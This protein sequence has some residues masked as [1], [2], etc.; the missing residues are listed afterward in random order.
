MIRKITNSSITILF[1]FLSS[2][3]FL[4]PNHHRMSFNSMDNHLK[5]WLSFDQWTPN[6]SVVLD[7]LVKL[8]VQF[9]LFFEV[10]IG[11]LEL[12][13]EYLEIFDY[14]E[15]VVHLFFFHLFLLFEGFFLVC[16]HLLF[17]F[18]Y[19]CYPCYHCT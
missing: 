2:Q 3:L 9:F 6:G 10:H 14:W 15:F 11:F 18:Y 8:F 19:V 17:C 1:P 13:V 4:R 12:V 7:Q 5:L 16:S